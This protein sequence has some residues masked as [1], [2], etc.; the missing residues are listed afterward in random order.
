MA[1]PT[2]YSKALCSLFCFCIVILY[3]VLCRFVVSCYCARRTTA[4]NLEYIYILILCCWRKLKANH[5]FHWTHIAQCK[6]KLLTAPIKNLHAAQNEGRTLRCDYVIW[7][8]VIVV[9]I[10]RYRCWA[11]D[12]LVKA[13]NQW[14]VCCIRV[15]REEKANWI[16]IDNL[17][18]IPC[19]TL[20]APLCAVRVQQPAPD[21]KGLAVVGNDFQQ[22]KLEDYRGKYLVLFFYP[23]DL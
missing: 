19:V 14:L 13:G 5:V 6:C 1:L 15:S 3:F 2:D 18:G 8:N 7:E 12:W 16:V 20:A 22:I 10:C 9:I 21:F 11:K 23:L 4:N 17:N